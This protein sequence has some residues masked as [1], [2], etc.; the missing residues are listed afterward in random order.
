MEKERKKFWGLT[1]GIWYKGIENG[2]WN[3][4]PFLPHY[5]VWISFTRIGM[6][7]KM[8]PAENKL[9]FLNRNLIH[10]TYVVF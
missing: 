6:E 2:K 4:I 7:S 8:I 3:L 5:H 10:H 9:L 1:V